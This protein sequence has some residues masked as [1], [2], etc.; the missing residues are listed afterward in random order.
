M[1]TSLLCFVVL[2]VQ[3][4]VVSLFKITNYVISKY[5][6]TYKTHTRTELGKKKV[7]CMCVRLHDKKYLKSFSSYW[8]FI[9]N[10]MKRDLVNHWMFSSQQPEHV[11]SDSTATV[12]HQPCAD[13]RRT[14]PLHAVITGSQGGAAPGTSWHMAY[15]DDFFP[16]SCKTSSICYRGWVFRALTHKFRFFTVRTDQYLTDHL[17]KSTVFHIHTIFWGGV[18]VSYVLLRWD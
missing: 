2:F 17:Q 14:C 15:L 10:E 3:Q 8:S 12:V 16:L 6:T 13:R 18:S 4:S 7:G 11:F 1:T 5:R 9:I